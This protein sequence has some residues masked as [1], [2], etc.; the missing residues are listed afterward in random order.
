MYPIWNTGSTNIIW[1]VCPGQYALYNPHVKHNNPL[2]VVPNFA[3]IN[4]PSFGIK[5]SYKSALDIPFEF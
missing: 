3:S 2:S 5:L 4:P 1:P